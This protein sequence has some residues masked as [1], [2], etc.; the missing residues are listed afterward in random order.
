MQVVRCDAI[1]ITPLRL[2]LSA[3]LPS[4]LHSALSLH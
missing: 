2:G 4:A 3:S 1:A